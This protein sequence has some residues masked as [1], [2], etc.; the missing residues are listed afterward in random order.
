MGW[1]FFCYLF[2]DT[3]FLKDGSVSVFKEGGMELLGFG[4][5]FGGYERGRGGEERERW[6]VD[7]NSRTE[8]S[9]GFCF[10]VFDKRGE[11]GVMED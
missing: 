6:M 7:S 10:G 5:F 1:A 9:M 11:K 4:G 2:S 3:V 8:V